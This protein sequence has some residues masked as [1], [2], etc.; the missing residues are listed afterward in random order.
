MTILGRGRAAVVVALALACA[1]TPAAHASPADQPSPYLRFVGVATVRAT[2]DRA[3]VSLVVAGT[4]ATPRA[5]QAQ[6]ARRLNRVLGRLRSF[7]VARDDVQTQAFRVDRN[8]KTKR[9]TASTYLVAR[10]YRLTALSRAL[11]AIIRA[12]GVLNGGPQ[13]MLEHAE[14]AYGRALEQA[15]DSA[16]AKAQL[17]AAK[18]RVALGSVIS[19]DEDG[20]RP[21]Y[22]GVGGSAYATASD[23]IQIRPGSLDVSAS[24]VVT[25]A[26]S[27]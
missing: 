21:L 24:V 19:V 18:L 27:R 2:P 6:L 15:I 1:A 16:Q 9:F 11:P 17:A 14:A 3:D 13:F 5:A 7:G 25:F 8:R 12:G 22:Y 4:A 20:A 26:Y 10:I 23:S